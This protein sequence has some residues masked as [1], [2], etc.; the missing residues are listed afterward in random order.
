[1]LGVTGGR[2]IEWFVRASG[3]DGVCLIHVRGG[4]GGNVSKLVE[5]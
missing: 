1:M 4:A 3:D 5:L 2:I